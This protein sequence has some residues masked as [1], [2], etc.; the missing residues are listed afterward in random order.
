Q[1]V[2]AVGLGPTIALIDPLL[3]R[4]MPP[5][6]AAWTGWDAFAHEFEGYLGR[7][8]LPEAAALCLKTI[9]LVAENLRE[10]VYNRMNHV[11][12]ENMCY[13]ESI[14]RISIAMGSGPSILHGFATHIGAITDCHHGRV[15]AMM[16]L[17]TQRYNEAAL[18]DRFAEMAG[19]MGVDTKGMTRMQ[20]ADKWFDEVERLLADLNIKTGHLHEQ[21]GLQQEDLEDLANRMSKGFY[22]ESNPRDT[23]F[24]EM[25]AL[26]ESMM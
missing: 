23:V 2:N 14:M 3:I 25:L 5:H 4:L 16:T 20:A 17:P 15:I 19:A 6:I 7:V 9:Q 13:A 11:A 24:D 26:L 22:K 18:P 8:H 10:F 21:V 1:M 12:C